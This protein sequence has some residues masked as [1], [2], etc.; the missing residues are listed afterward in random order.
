VW[1]GFRFELGFGTGVNF[2]LSQLADN[3]QFDSFENN[4]TATSSKFTLTTD[5][6]KTLVWGNGTAPSV[7]SVSFS[8]AIDV[9]DDL[10]SVNPAGANRFTL[11]QIPIAADA[12]A[13]P[14]PST[15]GLLGLSLAGLAVRLRSFER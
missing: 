13:V 14:E 3:L 1:K 7:S 5:E 6:M 11:R 10:S 12:E 4:S 2:V 9:P 8:F 15:F